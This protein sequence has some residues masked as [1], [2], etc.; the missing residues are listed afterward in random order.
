MYSEYTDTP[1]YPNL[2]IELANIVINYVYMN[3]NISHIISIFETGPG[4]TM[5]ETL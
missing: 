2:H 5:T 1:G 3:I 4:R